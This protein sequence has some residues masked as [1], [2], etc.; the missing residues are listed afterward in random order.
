MR[1]ETNKAPRPAGLPH[2]KRVGGFLFMVYSEVHISGRG[3]L[4]LASWLGMSCIA[5]GKAKTVLC[6]SS[7]LNSNTKSKLIPTPGIT[8]LLADNF[9]LQSRGRR[10]ATWVPPR[11]N[12]K[13][14]SQSRTQFQRRRKNDDAY[15]EWE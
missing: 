15:L 2:T 7:S 4:N 5:F 13:P 12:L 9:V 11:R 6:L 10:G 8:Q 14:H 3:C 1:L